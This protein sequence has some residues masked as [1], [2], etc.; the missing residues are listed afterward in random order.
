MW[1]HKGNLAALLVCALCCVFC[2]GL[3]SAEKGDK[4]TYKDLLSEKI[5]PEL[6]QKIDALPP[7]ERKSIAKELIAHAPDKFEMLFLLFYKHMDGLFALCEGISDNENL[8]PQSVRQIIFTLGTVYEGK[9]PNCEVS[10]KSKRIYE[11]ELRKLLKKTD[12]RDYWLPAVGMVETC[13]IK[14]LYD[15]VK[16]LSLSKDIPREEKGIIFRCLKTLE[17]GDTAPKEVDL[18]NILKSNDP[19]TLYAYAQAHDDNLVMARYLFLSLKSENPD[20]RLEAI[21]KLRKLTGR[22]FGYNP[23]APKEIREKALRQWNEYIS[24]EIKNRLNEK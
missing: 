16:E 5:S 17:G 15:D 8:S 12:D 9:V 6:F 4:I 21:V 19:I 7:A 14:S 2:G 10:E 11:G 13:K 24:S 1:I 18:E 22:N 20:T 3:H 23:A